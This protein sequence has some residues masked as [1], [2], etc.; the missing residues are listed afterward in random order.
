MKISDYLGNQ[1]ELTDERWH[2]II[3]EHPEVKSLKDRLSEILS[4]PDMVKRSGR[5]KDVLLYYRYY[6]D[7]LRGKYLI[8]VVKLKERPFLLTCYVTDKIKEGDVIWQRN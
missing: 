5:D 1:I 4:Q 2:H 6:P 8:V 3:I 7:I